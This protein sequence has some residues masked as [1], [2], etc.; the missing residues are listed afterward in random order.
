ME[1]HFLACTSL[2]VLVS[3]KHRCQTKTKVRE[4]G[5]EKTASMLVNNQGF[6]G[7]CVQEPSGRQLQLLRLVLVSVV[8]SRND[9]ALAANYITGH[10]RYLM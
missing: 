7:F 6:S 8:N 3:T 5:M 10:L 1:L 4:V 2:G 9:D